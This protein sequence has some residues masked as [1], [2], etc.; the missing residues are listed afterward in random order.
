MKKRFDRI[1]IVSGKFDSIDG[2]DIDFLC[3]AKS[4]GDWLVVGL[5]SD[6]YMLYF[7]K[8]FIQ[9]FDTRLKILS[10]IKYVDEILQFNDSDGSACH[11]LKKMKILYPNSEFVY[12]TE[13]DL[14]NRPESKIRGITF[15]VMKVGEN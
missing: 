9:N 5:N 13:E 15:E 7:N 10:S 11:L 12:L 1:I 2:D 8:G 6:D 14:Q 4:R 3:H